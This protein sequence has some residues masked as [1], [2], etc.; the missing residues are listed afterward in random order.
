MSYLQF[1][2][3]SQSFPTNIYVI[4][5]ITF[6]TAIN[7]I[8]QSLCLLLQALARQK[9]RGGFVGE[10]A[11]VSVSQFSHLL[12]QPQDLCFQRHNRSSAAIPIPPRLPSKT[13]FLLWNERKSQRKQNTSK[14]MCNTPQ[15]SSKNEWTSPSAT[16]Q[17]NGQ[18]SISCLW[19]KYFGG[20]YSKLGYHRSCSIKEGWCAQVLPW[21]SRQLELPPQHT[22]KGV[23]RVEWR[24]PWPGSAVI[25]AGMGT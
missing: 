6:L 8:C 10:D 16:Q 22:V 13:H 1:Q 21:F 12:T 19:E 7:A 25:P 3:S 15:P 9:G 20:N 23:M 2:D 11:R 5:W 18:G 17:G 4:I 24:H 14:S